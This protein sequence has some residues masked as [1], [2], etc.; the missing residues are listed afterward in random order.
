MIFDTL[1]VDFEQG[2]L[3]LTKD[4]V[5]TPLRT[6]LVDR[7]TPL[8]VDHVVLLGQGV[9]LWASANKNA[10]Q[11]VIMPPGGLPFASKDICAARIAR[12][13]IARSP[14]PVLA[15]GEAVQFPWGRLKLCT[16]WKE[17]GWGAYFEFC[18]RDAG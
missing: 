10:S 1:E 4:T 2:E 9:S 5:S 6:L 3:L 17:G 18:P 13:L 7:N 16:A 12:L 14:V 8:I 15:G 11:A